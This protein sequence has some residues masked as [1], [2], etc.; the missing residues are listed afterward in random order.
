MAAK[1][2]YAKG[3][4]SFHYLPFFLFWCCNFKCTALVGSEEPC[5]N[6]AFR[7]GFS[8]FVVFIIGVLHYLCSFFLCVRAYVCVAVSCSW[9]TWVLQASYSCTDF[10]NCSSWAGSCSARHLVQLF[11]K[12]S[13]IVH[14]LSIYLLRLFVSF[15]PNK[16]KHG[17]LT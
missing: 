8:Y 2:L 15:M 12:V 16:R 17:T 5:F 9:K 4:I 7:Q 11:C 3:F 14:F 6:T 13:F 1:Q 10:V